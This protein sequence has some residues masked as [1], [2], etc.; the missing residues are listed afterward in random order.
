MAESTSLPSNPSAS[1]RQFLLAGSAAVAGAV[2]LRGDLVSSPT[3]LELLAA[4]DGPRISVGYIEGSAG[5]SSLAAAL[6]GTRRI[7]PAA[8]MRGSSAL[9]GKPGRMWVRGFA[10]TG[11]ADAASAVTLDAHIP[12]PSQR[13]E[14][15][16]FY[17]FTHRRNP[18]PSTSAA[19]RVQIASGRDLRIGFRLDATVGAATQGATTVFTSRPKSGL[20]TLQPGVYLLGLQQGQWASAATLPPLDDSAWAG[21]QSLVLVVEEI[22]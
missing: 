9:V 13:G 4:G 15:I 21:L 11:H 16:P 18:Q 7:V 3:G 14:T 1:R 19:S 20:P 5:A 8:G 2:L 6:G 17:A 22:S 12:S 10:S